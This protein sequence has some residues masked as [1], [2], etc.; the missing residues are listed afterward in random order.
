[1]DQNVTLD[2]R[3]GGGSMGAKGEVGLYIPEVFVVLRVKVVDDNVADIV[4]T[5][6]RIIVGS[7]ACVL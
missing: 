2:S 7:G 6:G 3:G 4:L 1:M 5:L